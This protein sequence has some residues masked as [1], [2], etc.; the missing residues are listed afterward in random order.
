MSN[1]L[2]IILRTFYPVL[3]NSDF[4]EFWFCDRILGRF[5]IEPFLS[6]LLFELK[7]FKFHTDL[8]I[9]SLNYYVPEACPSLLSASDIKS[10]AFVS[11]G[12]TSPLPSR[13]TWK[14]KKNDVKICSHLTRGMLNEIEK[15]Y[16]Y[17]FSFISRTIQCVYVSKPSYI[18]KWILIVFALSIFYMIH[19]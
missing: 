18:E 11:F 12:D 16:S 7:I 19:K 2:V 4:K 1:Q 17:S 15:F 14:L 3:K 9:P 6:I 13:T 8:K 10:E 5:Q